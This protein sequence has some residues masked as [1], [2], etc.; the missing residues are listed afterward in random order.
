MGADTIA[1]IAGLETASAVGVMKPAKNAVA[2][3]ISIPTN[4]LIGMISYDLR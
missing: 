3:G 2:M 1:A 4:I